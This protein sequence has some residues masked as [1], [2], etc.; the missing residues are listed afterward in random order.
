MKKKV[1]LRKIGSQFIETIKSPDARLPVVRWYRDWDEVEK[2][3]RQIR[4]PRAEIALLKSAFDL[5]GDNA[6]I[7]MP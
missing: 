3:L 2:R 6:L 7:H 4:V 5:G 1:T